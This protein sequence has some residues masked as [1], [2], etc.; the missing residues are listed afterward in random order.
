[1]GSAAF[2]DKEKQFL[3]EQYEKIEEPFLYEYQDGWKNLFQWSPAIIMITTMVLG[4]LCA[5]NFRCRWDKLSD[6]VRYSGL[7]EPL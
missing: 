7:E 3:L 6:T 1:M 2:S 5:G 4:F